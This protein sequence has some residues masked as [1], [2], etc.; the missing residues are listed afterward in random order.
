MENQNEKN[1]IKFCSVCGNEI[2][3]YGNNAEPINSGICC[4][5]CNQRVILARLNLMEKEKW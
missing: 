5:T 4:D 3:G 2:T 1:H